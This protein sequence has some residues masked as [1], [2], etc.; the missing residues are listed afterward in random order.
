MSSGEKAI[1]ESDV[2][3]FCAKKEEEELEGEGKEEEAK[4]EKDDTESWGQS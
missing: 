3:V 1:L 4:G 2:I